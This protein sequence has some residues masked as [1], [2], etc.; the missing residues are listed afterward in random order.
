MLWASFFGREP[1]PFF[2]WPRDGEGI[3][4]EKFNKYIIPLLDRYAHK[5]PGLV[6]Q[7]EDFPIYHDT[8]V[9]WR[10][11]ELGIRDLSLPKSS[12]DLSPMRNVWRWMNGHFID[13]FQ[14]QNL[15]VDSRDLDLVKVIL[16]QCWQAIDLEL[17]ENNARGMP[18]LLEEVIRT[19][20]DFM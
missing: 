5:V 16:S 8:G 3:T 1:G 14:S 10:L 7:V 2:I 20:G 9:Q 6:L 4:P 15:N 11:D 19:N 12:P 18:G 13:T 17:L